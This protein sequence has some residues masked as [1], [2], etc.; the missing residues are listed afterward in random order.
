MNYALYGDPH[1]RIL[2]RPAA[3]RP[4]LLI[5][6]ARSVRWLGGALGPWSRSYYSSSSTEAL[7]SLN[8]KSPF[9]DGQIISSTILLPAAC[10]LA[11]LR[12]QVLPLLL[13]CS[14]S[15][16]QV[17][18]SPLLEHGT[19]SPR[20]SSLRQVL[21]SPRASTRRRTGS[22]STRIRAQTRLMP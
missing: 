17:F 1:L 19:S 13:S 8:N 6:R 9:H 7:I 12:V 18:A 16:A 3:P 14:C 21:L 11:L 2:H 4:L 10:S 15:S 20:A 22:C 5:L